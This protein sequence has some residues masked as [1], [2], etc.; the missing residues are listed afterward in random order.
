MSQFVPNSVSRLLCVAL[1]LLFICTACAEEADDPSMESANS[2]DA[3]TRV[4]DPAADST[5]PF[6]MKI[7]DVFSITGKG[8]VLTGNVSSGTIH[9][10][11]MVCVP[12]TDGTTLAREA[13][14]IEA[15][16]KM[17]D[18]A[19]QGDNVGVLIDDIDKG[20][21]NKESG[22]LHSDCD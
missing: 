13:V 15:F 6:R 11:D 8:V 4:P 14:G 20:L 16:R 10:N 5:E 17:L 22:V 7:M 19:T 1:S 21:I 3:T 18:S 12:L 2:A 9:V